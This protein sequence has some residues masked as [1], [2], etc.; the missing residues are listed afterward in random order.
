MLPVAWYGGVTSCGVE[1]RYSGSGCWWDDEW[2]PAPVQ[3]IVKGTSF[4]PFSLGI[5]TAEKFRLFED[6]NQEKIEDVHPVA[7]DDIQVW[8]DNLGA[9]TEAAVGP[10]GTWSTAD[11]TPESLKAARS[12]HLFLISYSPPASPLGSCHTISL[13]VP[14]ASQLLYSKEYCNLTAAGPD[15][16]KGTPKGQK[17]E[18]FLASGKQGKIHP[19]LQSTAFYESSEKTRVHIDVEF[20]FKEVEPH[21]WKNGALPTALLIAA[22]GKD[23]SVAAR[24]S[25]SVPAETMFES[26]SMF[27]PL[28]DAAEVATSTRYDSQIELPPGQYTLAVAYE[29][30]N[31]FGVVK[32]PL[33]IDSFAQN[34]FTISSIALC[35][36]V[37]DVGAVPVASEFVP[38]VAGKYEFTPAGDTVFRKGDSLMAYFELYEPEHGTLRNPLHVSYT[39][40]IANEQTGVVALKTTESADSWIRP[41]KSTISVA[42]EPVLSKLKLSPGKYEFEIQASD[43]AGRSTPQRKSE[44]TIE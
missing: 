25:E 6:G 15:P 37:R 33:V 35:K 22:Y 32:E 42:V 13:K 20:P 2:G 28:K 14:H 36:R 10:R 3:D 38:L 44:F 11:Y 12:A 41:G 21:S 43:S 40:Q 30:G 31:Y 5:L 39:M 26:F 8:T 23:G 19:M 4:S 9:H 17:L 1:P 27:E 16:L 29:H 18:E 24:L 7:P 34:Q